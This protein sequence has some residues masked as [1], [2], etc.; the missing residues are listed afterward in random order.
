MAT[1]DYKKIL[2]DIKKKNKGG[3]TA[4]I[5][6][7]DGDTIIRIL[8][9]HPNMAGFFVAFPFHRK[10]KGNDYVQVPCFNREP[11]DDNCDVCRSLQELRDSDDKADKKSYKDQMAK[12][13]YFFGAI[14]RKADPK[15]EVE[16]VAECGTM[17]LEEILK[18]LINPDYEDLL[19]PAKGRDVTVNRSGK[20]METKYKVLP[21]PNPSPIIPGKPKGSVAFIG[22][23]AEDTKLQDLMTAGDQFADEPEKVMIVWEGG[24][25]ALK[26]SNDDDK[27]TPAKKTTTAAPTKVVKKPAK[28]APEEDESEESAVDLTKPLKARDPITGDKRYK[29]ADGSVLTA[30]GRKSPKGLGEDERPSKPSK[31]YLKEFP[32]PIEDEEEEVE[33]AE[34][35]EESEEEEEAEP[36][37]PKKTAVKTTSKKAAVE[38]D[39]DDGLEELEDILAKHSG[40]KK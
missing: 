37:P 22:T 4:Y 19:D 35:V 15:D 38:P 2:E 33:E 39:E 32:E 9:G 10:G 14:Q 18:L 23:S 24:W 3:N 27:K 31:S 6:F 17:L 5:Q 28:P 12:D 40:K 8:P 16:E 36:T 34:E 29:Q 7:E 21:R 26:D 13:R 11:G 1:V 20:D 25:K 30:D